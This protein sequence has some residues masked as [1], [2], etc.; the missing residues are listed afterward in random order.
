[1][2]NEKSERKRETGHAAALSGWNESN[3]LFFDI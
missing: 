2:E 3:S 1:M